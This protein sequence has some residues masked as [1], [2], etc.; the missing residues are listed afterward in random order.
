MVLNLIKDTWL[1]QLVV[2]NV[3]HQYPSDNR[4]CRVL[5][6]SLLYICLRSNEEVIIPDTFYNWVNADYA[7]LG[8]EEK[9][10]V[11]VV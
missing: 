2:P 5:V 9:E 1:F 11:E 7:A 6:L 8:L 4:L 10:P 3:R